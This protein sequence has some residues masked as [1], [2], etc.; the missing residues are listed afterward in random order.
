MAGSTRSAVFGTTDAGAGLAG[1][2]LRTITQRTYSSTVAPSW[3]RPV[4]RT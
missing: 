4:V 2:R 1:S 3:L